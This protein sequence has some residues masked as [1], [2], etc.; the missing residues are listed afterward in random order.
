MLARN[1]NVRIPAL[2]CCS[3]ERERG[4]TGIITYLYIP[5]KKSSQAWILISG[6]NF[7]LDIKIPP[8]WTLFIYLVYQKGIISVSFP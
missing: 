7:G 6:G 1:V 4:Y 2:L 8:K 5:D 3:S